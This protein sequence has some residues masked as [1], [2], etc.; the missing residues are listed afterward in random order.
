MAEQLV[1]AGTVIGFV[2]GNTD[3]AI[4]HDGSFEVHCYIPNGTTVRI[5]EAYNVYKQ[6]S[7]YYIGTKINN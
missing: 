4:I 7:T 6:N 2:N 1:T 5:G 3:F